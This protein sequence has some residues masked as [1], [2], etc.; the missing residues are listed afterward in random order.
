MQHIDPA[1]LSSLPDIVG[2]DR[3]APYLA[4]QDGSEAE[5]LR[6]YAWNIEASAGLLGA[7]AALEVG[8]RN[9]IHGRL[10]GVFARADW[11][12]QAPLRASERGQIADAAAY[13]DRRRGVGCWSPGHLIAELRASF[14]ESLLVNRY[15]ASLWERGLSEAFPN[16][17]GRRAELRSRM[18]RLRLLRN[19]AAHHEPIFARD[20]MVD[21]GY[22]CDLA[23]YVSADLR[24][25]ITSHSRLPGIVADRPATISGQRTPRF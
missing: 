4:A 12:T 16:Y 2:S 14:W 22:I 23:G 18:E 24:T 6:L 25:W 19:R 20:L 3:F 1:T 5:G 9:A 10:T 11:W 8:V 13:L 15:H 7:F 17:S 21:H